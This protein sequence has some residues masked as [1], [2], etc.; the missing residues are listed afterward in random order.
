MPHVS[1]RP[2]NRCAGLAALAHLVRICVVLECAGCARDALDRQAL[3]DPATCASC[4]PDEYRQ[5][6]GSMHAYASDDPVLRALNARG[7]RDS[8]GA[9]GGLC[10]HC[11]APMATREG[12]TVDGSNLDEVPRALHGV[13]CYYCHAIDRVEGDHNNPLVLADDGAMR[14]H[15]ANAMPTNAHASQYSPL[16][17]GNDPRSA[18]A[19][20][21]CHDVTTS[22]PLETTYAE[23]RA[24]LFAQPGPAQLSC[25]QCHMIGSDA[26]AAAV[27]GAPVRRVGSHAWPGLDTALVDWPEKPAQLAAIETDLVPTVS[28]KLCVIPGPQNISVTL[29]NIAG[30][31]AWPSGATHNRRAWVEV[32]ARKAGTVLYQS[33]VV[34]AGSDPADLADPDLW[35]LGQTLYGAD[36]SPVEFAWQ[37]ASATSSLL[38]AAV[39]IDRTDPRFYHAVTRTYAAPLVDEVSIRL[40]IQ[41]LAV[42]PLAALV[43]SGDLD[44]A[45]AA[46]AGMFEVTSAA[47]TWHLADGY[48]CNPPP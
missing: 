22:F 48:G 27:A 34:P 25:A 1:T 30:G 13:T 17:D 3:L 36:G 4:H 11:H 21:S 8:G 7:Q 42:R 6:S 39:T 9:L 32:V 20:G 5:W 37:A 40:W 19:C 12:A 41:P 46:A 47:K 10:V 44:P 2:R 14:G 26:R 29:D 43:A 18:S 23:W 24:S 38:P 28:S 33:G 15:L 35:L 31:H 45:I 16:L